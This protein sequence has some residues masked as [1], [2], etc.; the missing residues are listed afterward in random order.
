MESVKGFRDAQLSN[1][2]TSQDLNTAIN[3]MVHVSEGVIAIMGKVKNRW[4][5][6]IRIIDRKLDD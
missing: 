2:G 4:Q 1:H 3:R 5:E 6:I